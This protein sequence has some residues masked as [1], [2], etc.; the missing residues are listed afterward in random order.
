MP[1]RWIFI[2]FIIFVNAPSWGAE[3]SLRCESLFTK[4][5]IFGIATQYFSPVRIDGVDFFVLTRFKSEFIKSRQ[6]PENVA[7]VEAARY[8]QSRGN[9]FYY[10]PDFFNVGEKHQNVISMPAYDGVELNSE[11]EL[12]SRVQVKGTIHPGKMTALAIQK[13]LLFDDLQTWRLY[14]RDNQIS[15]MA[16]DIIREVFAINSKFN[17]YLIFIYKPDRS[18]SRPSA[19]QLENVYPRLDIELAVMNKDGDVAEIKPKN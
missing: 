10:I 13:L 5:K 18:I 14:F 3:L 6:H 15:P 8:I 2:L 17:H 1:I 19:E 12:I 9:K 7:I 4:T 11:L 16:E